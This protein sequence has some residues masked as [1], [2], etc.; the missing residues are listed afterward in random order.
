MASFVSISVVVFLGFFVWITLPFLV[1]IFL[2]YGIS[3]FI[4]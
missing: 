2:L 4:R 1:I 3:N